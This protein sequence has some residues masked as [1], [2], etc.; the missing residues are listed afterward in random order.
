LPVRKKLI[1]FLKKRQFVPIEEPISKTF[2]VDEEEVC[3]S[4][5]ENN[6]NGVHTL[7]VSQKQRKKNGYRI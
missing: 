4:C 5:Y 1:L 2:A 6:K 7:P 3:S